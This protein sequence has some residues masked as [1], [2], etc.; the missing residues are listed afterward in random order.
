MTTSWTESFDQWKTGVDTHF[1]RPLQK[2]LGITGSKVTDTGARAEALDNAIFCAKRTL[3]MWTLYLPQFL[4]PAFSSLLPRL[5][6]SHLF[7]LLYVRLP[8]FIFISLKLFYSFCCLVL[9][10][11]YTVQ[12]LIKGMAPATV[13][14]PSH[15]NLW[16]QNNTRRMQAQRPIFHV[17]LDS[18]KLTTLTITPC[19]KKKKKDTPPLPTKNRAGDAPQGG[20][21]T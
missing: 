14:N 10:S 15:L 4:L 19:L 3:T 5:P 7:F 12:N 1:F 20:P 2:L 8:F 21:P 6:P 17:I 11:T 13:G 18:V 16:T 9:F